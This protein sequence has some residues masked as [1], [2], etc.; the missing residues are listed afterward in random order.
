MKKKEPKPVDRLVGSRIRFRRN[1]LGVSQ[2]ALGDA[3]GITFQQVQKY[4][5]GTNRIGSS[6]LCEIAK[7]LKVTPS[8]FFEGTDAAGGED[9]GAL[10]QSTAFL[11]TKDGAIIAKLFPTMSHR[12][13]T[14]VRMLVENLAGRKD[15]GDG[16]NP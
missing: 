8:Y 11:A 10:R 3:I 7:V 1:E 4:E 14:I 6:R 13:Q 2:E 12:A 15:T 16:P 9:E 5:K